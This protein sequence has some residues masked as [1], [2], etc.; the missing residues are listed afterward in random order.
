MNAIKT[1]SLVVAVRE[2]L[3]PFSPEGHPDAAAMGAYRRK[4]FN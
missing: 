4:K 3:R 1:E 2:R